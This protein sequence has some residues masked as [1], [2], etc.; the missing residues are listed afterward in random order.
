MRKEIRAK[1]AAKARQENPR[2]TVPYRSETKTL[3]VFTADYALKI[4]EEQV[5]PDS[6]FWSSEMSSGVT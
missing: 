4:R 6:A 3:A 1:R 5:R 2:W